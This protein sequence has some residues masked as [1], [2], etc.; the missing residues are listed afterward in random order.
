MKKTLI[1]FVG[2]IS[3]F[4]INTV[5]A[6]TYIASDFYSQ[7]D[8][9]IENYNK[10]KENINH[11]IELW[12]D[13]HSSSFPYYFIIYNNDTLADAHYILYSSNSTEFNLK[14]GNFILN[15]SH[16]VSGKSDEYYSVHNKTGYLYS[17]YYKVSTNEY[18]VASSYVP[19]FSL[20]GNRIIIDSNVIPTFKYKPYSYSQGG[21][22]YYE[23]FDTI[24]FPSFSSSST[25]FTTTEF[26]IKDGD[27][28][29]TLKSLYDGSYIT[30]ELNN[31]V[32]INLNEYPYVALSLKDYTERDMFYT[33]VYVK[34][35]YCLTPVYNYGMTEKK[36]IITGSKTQRCSTY[37]NDFTLVRT[38]ILDQDIKNHAI[39]YLKA[40]DISK[41]N[42]VKVDTS[43]F[44][45]TYITE[46]TEDNPYVTVNGKDYPT[47]SYNNLTDSATISEDED[48]ISGVTCQ[49]GDFNCYSKYNPENIFDNI[50]SSPLDFLKDIWSSV[51]SIFNIITEFI[52]LLPVEMQTFLYLS[53]MIAIILGLLKLIL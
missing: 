46:E 39:Y 32:T 38:Y 47:I 52:T 24:K 50:F 12:E 4:G 15:G 19:S 8:E 25:D 44:D 35:Q 37:Y 51:T 40:Y 48:Y 7:F 28:L 5:K 27:N 41:E 34:G 31:Y 45:I 9:H 29:P 22:N 13:N 1:L 42:I 11:L 23:D 43:I 49:V 2:I 14:T 18:N 10:Y 30:N 26:E 3:L 36:D 6:D 33:N 16:F 21:T 20:K 17:Y 53:F